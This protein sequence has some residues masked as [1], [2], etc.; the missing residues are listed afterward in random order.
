MAPMSDNDRQP[1][2]EDF[3]PD[4]AEIERQI[5]LIYAAL[6]IGPFYWN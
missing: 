1:Q 4:P 3:H 2:G 6:T 5:K